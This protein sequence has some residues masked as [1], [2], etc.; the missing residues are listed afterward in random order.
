[1]F[2][3]ENIERKIKLIFLLLVFQFDSG[4]KFKCSLKQR[5]II[6]ISFKRK[7]KSCAIKIKKY[8]CYDV[9]IIDYFLTLFCATKV[10]QYKA[11]SNSLDQY[12]KYYFQLL[13]H[14]FRYKKIGV[15]S[16]SIMKRLN[17]CL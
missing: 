17:C 13:L 2:V 16:T 11:S 8:S 14:Q 5:Y 3:T 10:L 7:K 15:T 1:M 4:E 9:I 6:N 12:P